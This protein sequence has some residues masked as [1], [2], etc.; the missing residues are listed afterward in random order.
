MWS[1]VCEDV[2]VQQIEESVCRNVTSVPFDSRMNFKKARASKGCNYERRHDRVLSA[3]KKAADVNSL[4]TKK[5]NVKKWST[6]ESNKGKCYTS[7][8]SGCTCLSRAVWCD[9]FQA[10]AIRYS[11]PTFNRLI[12][13]SINYI[14]DQ[15]LM[16]YYEIPKRDMRVPAEGYAVYSAVIELSQHPASD[17]MQWQFS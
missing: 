14:F 1:I 8:R 3:G 4:L 2:T 5:K 10:S 16:L 13:L 9:V 15:P 17:H 11:F 6:C 12:N 7:H